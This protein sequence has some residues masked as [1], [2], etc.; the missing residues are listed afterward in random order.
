MIREGEVAVAKY[1]DDT[2]SQRRFDMT[3]VVIFFQ[4]VSSLCCFMSGRPIFSGF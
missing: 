4:A 2:I 1:T 3:A